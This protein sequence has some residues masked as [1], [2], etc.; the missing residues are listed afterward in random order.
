VVEEEVLRGRERAH[1]SEHVNE[2][3]RASERDLQKA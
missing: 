1:A 2:S 3:E